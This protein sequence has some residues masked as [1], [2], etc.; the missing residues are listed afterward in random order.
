MT[1]KNKLKTIGR[2]IKNEIKVYQAVIKDKRTPMLG[3]IFLGMAVGYFFLPFDLIPDF[4]PIIGHLDDI[5]IIPA[6]VIIALKIIPREIVEEYRGKF[7][8]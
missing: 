1:L 7:K 4:I 3:K 6:L 2:N 8:G 5:I